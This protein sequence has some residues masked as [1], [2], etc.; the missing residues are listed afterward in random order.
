MRVLPP[1]KGISSRKTAKDDLNTLASRLTGAK[2]RQAIM[3]HLLRVS[4]LI[5]SLL[6]DEVIVRENQIKTLNQHA[7]QDAKSCWV[8]VFLINISC[9][10]V[11]LFVNEGRAYIR[12]VLINKW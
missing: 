10:R 8:S 7:P 12:D 1:K 5:S 6:Q 2:Q 4:P 11:D 9:K 3:E